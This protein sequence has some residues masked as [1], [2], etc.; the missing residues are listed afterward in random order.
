MNKF[1]Q[2]SG[3]NPSIRLVLEPRSGH[4]SD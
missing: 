4:L 2:N 1:Y 3:S